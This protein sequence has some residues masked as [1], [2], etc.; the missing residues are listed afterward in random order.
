MKGTL[1]REALRRI[2]TAEASR[3]MPEGPALVR[4]FLEAMEPG[5]SPMTAAEAL[6]DEYGADDLPTVVGRI[7]RALR[8][9]RQDENLD[10]GE[11][12]ALT[13]VEQ[14]L[15]TAGLGPA[16]RPPRSGQLKTPRRQ[17]SRSKD[18]RPLGQRNPTSTPPRGPQRPMV[19]LGFP[20]P[21]GPG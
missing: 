18:T 11:V 21:C 3:R 1:T 8:A 19:S 6:H 7:T 14:E 13:R 2:I 5:V 4:A 9:Y 15:M 12:M 20:T 16:G 10:T 17:L